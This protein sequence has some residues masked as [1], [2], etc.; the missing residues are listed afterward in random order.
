MS[1]VAIEIFFLFLLILSNGLFA[2]SEI[3][4]VSSRKARLEQRADA[5][6]HGAKT[7]LSLISSPNRFFST[8]QV[9]VSLIGV[10]SGA[11]GGATLAD[12]L[13]PAIGRIPALAPYS[14]A[15]AFTLVVL[16]ITYFTL[17]LGELI[18]KRLGLNDPEGVAMR[19]A[20]PMKTVA[21]IT[22]P[23]VRLLSASTDL[24]LRVLGVHP[25]NEPPVT[26][27][28]V[29]LMIEQ[30]TQVGVFAE[31]EQDMVE[32]VFRLG[33]RRVGAL[34]TPR[35][36]IAW[37]DTDEPLE[38]NLSVIL[39]SQHSRFPVGHGSLDNVVGFLNAKDLLGQALADHPL[40]LT[41]AIEK[42]LFVPESLPALRA[43]EMFRSSGNQM[44]LVIDEFGGL[45]G[46]VTLYDVLE[47]IVGDIPVEGEEFEA[48]AIQREDGSWLFDG[49]LPVDEFKDILDI[50]HLPGEGHIG[51]QTVGG[52]VMSQVG[53][54][55][56]TGDKF[57]Y[58]GWNFEVLDMD[59]RRVDKVLAVPEGDEEQKRG[60]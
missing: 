35:T 3:A 50:D 60:E 47:A 55:P 48:E 59:G 4:L 25:T 57:Q 56:K 17:V 6:D 39:Q 28:E 22:W 1:P 10:L 7:A 38:E 33:E 46:L 26:E 12:D 19:V 27:E 37:I 54:I 9:G 43:L 16:I 53:K 21:T 5:G 32:S 30:G 2:M 51:Y 29:R 23:V 8:V 52:F 15:I 45:Q 31:A 42:A 34:M 14:H 40:N 41:A 13:A 49:M 20:R 44:A 58:G 24:G 36:D 11:F 18:P